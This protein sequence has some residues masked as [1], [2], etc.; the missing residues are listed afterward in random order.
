HPSQVLAGHLR[1]ASLEGN[2]PVGEKD[3]AA[4]EVLDDVRIVVDEDHRVSGCMELATAIGATALEPCITHREDL[5]EHQD[6]AHGAERDR[7]GEARLH[8]ARVVLE[9]EA[10]EAL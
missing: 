6:L 1:R 7:V 3:R 8:S 5:V 2:L 10:R 9:L 4:A